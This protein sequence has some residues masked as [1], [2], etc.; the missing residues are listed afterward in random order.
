MYNNKTFS[1]I[2]PAFNEEQNIKETIKEFEEIC[3]FDEIIVVDNNSLD[4]TA[5]EI[6]KTKSIYISESLQGYG[7]ALRK[8]LEV[9]KSDYLVMCEP[10]GT[11]SA[12][13][14]Y[15]FLPYLSDFDCVFGTRTYKPFIHKGAKMYTL[16]RWGNFLVAKF[17]E[18]LFSG[19]RL[20]D[21]GCTYKLLSKEA[22]NEIN[23]KLSVVGSEFQPELMINLIISKKKIIEIPVNYLKRK[24]ESKITNN[25]FSTSILAMKM[26]LLIIKLRLKN[27]F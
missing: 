1:L 27:F 8:G 24:G 3:F 13:D 23:E 5:D 7:A 25:F 22:Y 14:I 11:F 12:K 19:P 17:L 21:V 18:L 2:F 20:S 9:A 15:K 26:I 6:K 16:L 10:D 4:N